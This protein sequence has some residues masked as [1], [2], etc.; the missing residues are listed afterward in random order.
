MTADRYRAE[1][2]KSGRWLYEVQLVTTHLIQS[3]PDV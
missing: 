2:R 3:L 1:I